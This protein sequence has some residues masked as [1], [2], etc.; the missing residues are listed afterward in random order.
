[1][2]NDVNTMEEG[3]VRTILEKLETDILFECFAALL[4]K[5]NSVTEEK[6]QVVPKDNFRRNYKNDIIPAHEKNDFEQELFFEKTD[7]GTFIMYTSRSSILDYLPEDLYVEPDNTAEIWNDN[8]T[9]KTP[10]EIKEYKEQVKAQLKSAKHFFRPLEVEYNKIRI[11]RELSEVKQLEN[12]DKTL[13]IF[14]KQF[15]IVDKRWR[16]F[17][18]T[19]HLVETI[20]GDETKTKALIEFVLDKTISL[21]FSIEESLKISDDEQKS[22]TGDTMILGHNIV[23]GNT[24]Y[25]YLEICTLTLEGLTTSE[26]FEYF[27]ESS[28]SRKLINEI[29]NYYFPLN[30]AVRLDFSITSDEEYSE[31]QVPVQ[32]LG[33]SSTLA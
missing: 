7:G 30:I 13:E 4:I 17:V 14:W 3:L 33:Y 22:L 28:N 29:I 9:K 12:F 8:E 19:L 10:N 2:V 25:D 32:V 21:S 1:M 5:K 16:R 24:I 18:R 31:E 23:L 26:F 11:R 27:D 20:V 15:P 6:I